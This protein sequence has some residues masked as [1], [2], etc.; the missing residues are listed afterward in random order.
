L[1]RWPTWSKDGCAQQFRH[2]ISNSPWQHELV[3]AQIGLDADPLLGGQP[4]SCPILDETSFPK[5]ACRA[6]E[7]ERKLSNLVAHLARTA[8]SS[9]R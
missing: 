8:S 2:F 9:D 7:V 5:H 3:V 6:R 1:R 4:D